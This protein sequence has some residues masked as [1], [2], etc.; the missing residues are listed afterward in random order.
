MRAG[1][2]GALG[3]VYAHDRVEREVARGL[4]TLGRRLRREVRS[5]S[6]EV[7][8]LADSDQVV[9][10]DL[11][12]TSENDE[13]IEVRIDRVGVSVDLWQAA[14]GGGRQ[15][16]QKVVVGRV[17]VIVPARE[18]ESALD[19]LR[20]VGKS[21]L[22]AFRKRDAGPKEA[23]RE[24]H[25]PALEIGTV[26]LLL[27]RGEALAELG[28]GDV[29]L[30][31]TQS[32]Q[33]R[34][35]L[36]GRPAAGPP[37]EVSVELD[38]ASGAWRV[39]L[40]PQAPL[41]L[42]GPIPVRIRRAT[43]SS[44]DGVRVEAPRAVLP[45]QGLTVEAASATV[46]WGKDGPQGG[47]QLRLDSPQLT[48]RRPDGAPG[49]AV[50][51]DGSAAA[52]SVSLASIAAPPDELALVVERPSGRMTRGAERLEGRA[53]QA[54]IQLART[55]EAD[56]VGYEPT[57]FSVTEATGSA[58]DGEKRAEIT[59]QGAR[60][61]LGREGARRW[62]AVVEAHV[63]RAELSGPD[64][65]TALTTGRAAWTDEGGTAGTATL[66]ALT[67]DV[68]SKRL[69]TVR[70]DA[71]SLGLVLDRTRGQ[72]TVTLTRFRGSGAHGG[73]SADGRGDT[74]EMEW[75]LPMLGAPQLERVA[76]TAPV[77]D[78]RAPLPVAARV[79]EARARVRA[80]LGA[81]LDAGATPGT[82]PP[83]A[84][85]AGGP[86]AP[87]PPLRLMRLDLPVP[88]RSTVVSLSRGKVTVRGN[89]D[90]VLEAD[91]LRLEWGW[92][93]DIP[94]VDVSGQAGTG[95]GPL[96]RFAF[97]G[98]LDP[99]A[100]P[101]QARVALSGIP[102]GE[103]LAPRVPKWQIPAEMTAD[104][105]LDVTW[106]RSR[107][108]VAATG[109]AALHA[110]GFHHRMLAEEP[111]RNVELKA[112]GLRLDVQLGAAPTVTLDVAQLEVGPARFEVAA[113]IGR[114][115]RRPKLAVNVRYPQ[116]PCM[117]V[118]AAVP[119]AILGPLTGMRVG[120]G[121]RFEAHLALDFE[122][123]KG[124]E[125]D[126]KGDWGSCFMRSMGPM[127]DAKLGALRSGSFVFEWPEGVKVGPGSG[128]YV[129]L[130]HMPE[131]IAGGALM[132]EDGLFYRHKGFRL[133]SI[134]RALKYTLQRG[135]FWY[136]GSTITQQL[137]KNLFLD[138]K[139]VLAR[140]IREAL[141]TWSLER[142]FSKD[143]IIEMYLNVIEYGPGIYGIA[144]ASRFY[145]GKP[146]HRLTPLEVAFLMGLKPNPRAGYA[147]WRK[148]AT[149]ERWKR[150]L[151]SIM[152]RMAR[153]GFIPIEA[154]D[155]AAPYE[156]T[157]YKP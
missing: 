101:L 124:V 51:V 47:V 153:S 148:N 106:H 142:S 90:G 40:E 117:N 156:L 23:T 27:R 88:L 135:R 33:V 74:V 52:A 102:V 94:R 154:V 126:L 137:V 9:V 46:R 58:G 55:G 75:H 76:A 139:K 31:V 65:R 77:L 110:G 38:P 59:V 5:G 35:G 136:G 28:T 129:P 73:W 60:G 132:T 15:A 152:M 37:V 143:F 10:R 57:A 150:H 26:A 11:V 21:E 42:P 66:D 100:E 53:S 44:T 112:T 127:A 107:E 105:D 19:A 32:G 122:R 89:D 97:R 13:R 79:R 18:G 83:D 41:D 144:N 149:P 133:S 78:V 109:S 30:E 54:V 116:Q 20:R 120:G 104:L 125:L 70:L 155:E 123:P 87:A 141:I 130:G 24:R 39:A 1:T 84:G 147:L 14:R 64:G 72:A 61:R 98:L 6:I 99:D 43:A 45:G 138:R 85:T 128:S 68:R 25:T 16:L 36:T 131:F 134:R 8:L 67:A 4:Q 71:G 103:W 111:V 115:S 91:A 49:G 34:L 2:A 108:L 113:S 151:K 114:L 69:G 62:L 63:A 7:A 96:R 56:S 140:K 146:P 119:D 29:A 95:D 118:I 80:L 157:F 92:D 86:P 48:L 3:W 17:Q 50:A 93:G 145:F 81:P 121:L 82:R 22:D 12:L